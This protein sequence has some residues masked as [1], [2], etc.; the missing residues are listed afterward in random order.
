MSILVSR[1]TVWAIVLMN[2]DK[3]MLLD[4]IAIHPDYQGKGLGK[5]IMRH[6]EKEAREQGY[7][8]IYLYTHELMTENIEMYKFLNYV[9]TERRFEKGRPRVYMCKSLI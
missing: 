8:E 7:K 4:N 2:F 9:E 1:F 6:A 5:M 3:G